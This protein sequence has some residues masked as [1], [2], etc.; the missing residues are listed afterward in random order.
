[1]VVDVV[2]ARVVAAK[3]RDDE[4]VIEKYDFRIFGH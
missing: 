2:S 4:G 3:W 1:M